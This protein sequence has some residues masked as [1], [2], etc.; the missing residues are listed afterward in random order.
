MGCLFAALGFIVKT[1]LRVLMLIVKL[2]WFVLAKTGL[3][4]VGL[5]LLAAWALAEFGGIDMY[6]EFSTWYYFGLVVACVCSLIILIRNVSGKG[7][8]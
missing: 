5:Y 3:I 7:R 8:K 6:G 1:V 4:V 2:L